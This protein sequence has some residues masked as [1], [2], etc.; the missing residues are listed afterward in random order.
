VATSPFQAVTNSGRWISPF[1]TGE[2]GQ[3]GDAM[4]I[5]LAHEAFAMGLH[6]AGAD[7]KA[8]GDFLVAQALSNAG[9]DFALGDWS[10]PRD[11]AP[12]PLPANELVEGD[13]RDVGAEE[14]LARVDGWIACTYSSGDD[15]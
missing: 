3:A 7:V 6:S 13:P 4:D 12:S 8:A 14:G 10:A 9:Q 2:L 15:C 1:A 11:R 5:E